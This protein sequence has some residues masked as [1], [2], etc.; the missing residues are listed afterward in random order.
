MQLFEVEINNR[1]IKKSFKCKRIK[2]NW[3]DEQLYYLADS[4]EEAKEFVNKIFDGCKTSPKESE[5][6]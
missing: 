3:Y 4:E 5:K 6:V 2:G 1:V